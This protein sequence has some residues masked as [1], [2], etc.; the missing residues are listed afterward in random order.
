MTRPEGRHLGDHDSTVSPAASSRLSRSTNR[1]AGWLAARRLQ[2]PAGRSGAQR[3]G[4]GLGVARGVLQGLK[5]KINLMKAGVRIGR[6]VTGLNS[7]WPPLR[8][9]GHLARQQSPA[10]TP[11][12]GST[13]PPS[14]AG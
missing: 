4:V 12:T 10:S 13:H 11:G 2:L 3:I 9:K 8:V 6:I 1:S 7:A 14:D 5:K